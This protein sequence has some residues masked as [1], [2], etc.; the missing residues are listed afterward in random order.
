MG[1]LSLVLGVTMALSL[2][3]L[4][5]IVWAVAVGLTSATVRAFRTTEPRNAS[6]DAGA[7]LD[8]E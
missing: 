1:W 7:D 3:G 6:I 5:P 8:P 2:E 4:V